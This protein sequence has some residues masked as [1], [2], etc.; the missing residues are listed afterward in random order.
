VITDTHAVADQAARDADTLE[1]LADE[2]ELCTIA[3]AEAHVR[4]RAVIADLQLAVELIETPPDMSRKTIYNALHADSGGVDITKLCMFLR[5]VMDGTNSGAKVLA[6]LHAERTRT[7]SALRGREVG[8]RVRTLSKRASKHEGAP[9]PVQPGL[10]PTA[11]AADHHEDLALPA[12]QQDAAQ[13]AFRHGDT[14]QIMM[15]VGDEENLVV[16]ED[17]VDLARTDVPKVD[18]M[19]PEDAHRAASQ[20]IAQANSDAKR[21]TAKA[22]H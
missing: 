3:E 2:L 5:A 10:P 11:T 8:V 12:G 1:D 15:R 18:G 9:A 7:G 19:C 13:E 16:P 14:A 22:A 20:S 17:V 6:R 4:L 21:R